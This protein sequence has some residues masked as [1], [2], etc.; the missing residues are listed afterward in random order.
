MLRFQLIVVCLSAVLMTGCGGATQ[1]TSNPGSG[2]GSATGSIGYT[3][4]LQPTTAGAG[5][6]DLPLII[7]G[8]SSATWDD[9]GPVVTKVVWDVNGAKTF[10]A[11]T[12][13][14][15]SQLTAIV[16]SN[17]LASPGTAK[18]WVEAYDRIEGQ[19]NCCVSQ[20]V[21]FVVTP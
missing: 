6:P 10:L 17:L 11:S 3:I 18:V 13:E 14:S 2:G 12:I 9:Q 21:N 5:S 1:S 4:T 20:S 19:V 15:P 7:T 16:P 8:P